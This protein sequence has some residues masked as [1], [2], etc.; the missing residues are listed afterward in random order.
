MCY[1]CQVSLLIT[2][3][4]RQAKFLIKSYFPSAL[5]LI[6]YYFLTSL[7]PVERGEML[8]LVLFLKRHI[9]CQSNAKQG[10]KEW[11]ER[12]KKRY[13]I[14]DKEMSKYFKAYKALV[15]N[16]LISQHSYLANDLIFLFKKQIV[17][18]K[19]HLFPRRM[20][21]FRFSFRVSSHILLLH[22]FSFPSVFYCLPY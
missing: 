11:E 1:L 3:Y 6:R 18:E 15:L 14:L 17:F 2:C 21:M 7:L 12:A 8:F 22:A 13:C 4:L 16:M 19:S 20:F 10:K 5:T 9:Y